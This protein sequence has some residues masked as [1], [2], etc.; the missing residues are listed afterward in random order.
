M[1]EV[2]RFWRDP[3]LP[4]VE[5]RRVG[6]GRQVCYAAHSH[7]SFSIGVI[8]GGRSTYLTG[9][10]RHEVAAGST[11]LMNPGV[12]HTC[13]PIQGEP[14]SYLMLFVDMPWLLARGFALPSATLS[15]SAVLYGQL[16]ALFAGLFEPGNEG[17][18][19]QLE[20]F[21]RGLA[22]VLE[23]DASGQPPRHP[24]LEL[25]AAFIRAHRLDPLTLEDICAAAGLSR[26]YLI[27]A[28]GKRF[29]LTPHGYLLDQR[30]QH[31]RAQL[32][33]GRPIAEVALEAGF[34]DQA[35]LQRAFKRH[36]ATTPGHYRNG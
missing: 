19:A 29:G 25:A 14:W 35:H 6:D 17:R 33:A 3:A 30:V 36:L 11:V 24:R 16:L 22:Q 21:F 8:T 15:T 34:A 2:S 12:V 1:I 31:A 28:F 20:A 4:F 18:E 23:A 32:R 9:N 13:N 27:R 5:A 7:E 26:A 10:A